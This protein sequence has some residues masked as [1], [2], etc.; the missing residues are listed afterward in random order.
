MNTTYELNNLRKDSDYLNRDMRATSIVSEVFSA[1]VNGKEVGAIKGADKA[2]NYIKE[3]GV[4]A[5]NGDFGAVAELN[6]LRRFVIE[7]PLLQ[8]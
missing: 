8:E 6:T 2:V 4:R 1:M 7:T 5:E 3:L